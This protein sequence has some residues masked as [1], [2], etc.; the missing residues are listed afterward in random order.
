LLILLGVA[1]FLYLQYKPSTS[2]IQDL[3]T[4]L[5]SSLEETKESIKKELNETNEQAQET[6]EDI[7]PE[8]LTHED[9]VQYALDE[10]NR[11]RTK[12]GQGNVTLSPITCGQIHA[13]NLLELGCL[14]HWDAEG[15]KPYM[16][17][18]IAG[19]MGA[20]GEN[21][22]WMKST[23]YV[24]PYEAIEKL[25][26]NMIYD[27]ADS[28]WGHRDNLLDPNHNRVSIGVAYDYSNLF[29]VQDFEDYYFE[30]AEAS[31]D[32]TVYDLKYSASMDWSPDQIAIYYDPLPKDLSV[33][34][35]SKPP[36]D[37]GYDAGEYIGGV[38]PKRW[39]MGEGITINAQEWIISGNEFHVTFDMNKALSQR[40]KGVYT[41]LLWD[42]GK[43]YT[44]YSI[45]Y[46]P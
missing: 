44:T 46:E 5:S 13:E 24:D 43:Y 14:S 39:E 23:G 7:L 15:M 10:I 11:E 36:Y 42:S 6:F 4:N 41:L 19:G 37:H 33:E 27:D 8:P 30:S 16:R 9:L 38:V 26:W 22:A 40:G 35:L 28:N 12:Q 31:H 2:D 21:C 17:Y 34:E 1:G 20:V 32:G 29:L 45:W 3:A 25:T 18:S